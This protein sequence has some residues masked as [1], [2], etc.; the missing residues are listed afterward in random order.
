M[1]EFIGYTSG[2]PQEADGTSVY[3]AFGAV[4]TAQRH[5]WST[6]GHPSCH[7]A[8][9]SPKIINHPLDDPGGSTPPLKNGQP[10]SPQ[11]AWACSVEPVS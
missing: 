8:R 3:V 1:S 6:E 7:E 4:R 2:V 5:A 11:P 10:S 9:T